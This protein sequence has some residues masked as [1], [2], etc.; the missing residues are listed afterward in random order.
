MKRKKIVVE[1]LHVTGYAAEGKALGRLDGKVIFVDGAVPGDVADVF[2]TRNKKEWAEGKAIKIKQ[3]SEE[4]TEPFCIHFGIC[5]GCKWQ[6]LPYKQQLKY[7][8]QE[9]VDAFRKT[10]KLSEAPVLPIIGSADT[11]HYRN[12]PEFTFSN[13]KFITPDELEELA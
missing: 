1:D 7:K 5:G 4:R 8:E 6:M 10:G 13:K 12:K 2:I 3:Y 11:I 9:T